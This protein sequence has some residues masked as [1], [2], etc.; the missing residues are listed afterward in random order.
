MNIPIIMSAFGT[1]SKAMTTYN[2]LSD[3]IQV[4]FP[5]AEII[6]AYSSKKI[7]RRLNDQ[8]KVTVLH[9]EEVLKNLAARDIAK[10]ILQSLH[11]F[12]GT[13]FHS[14]MQA[15]KKSG[16]ECAIGMPLLTSP[17]TTTR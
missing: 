11:L 12:P 16:L 13:E 4:H 7:N 17:K 1:T 10:V 5:Q 9:P 2:Q 6:W 3:R 15:G 8:Q 14:L